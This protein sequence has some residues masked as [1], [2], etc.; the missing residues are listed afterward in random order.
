MIPLRPA[1]SAVVVVAALSGCSVRGSVGSPPAVS[2]DTLEST[3]ADRL[4]AQVGQRPDSVSCPDRLEGTAGD[5]VRCTLTSGD[6]TYGITVTAKSVKDDRVGFGI[7]V[8]EAPQA[9]R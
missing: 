8:D 3:I 2:T 1:L 4:E 5:S 9:S 6:S 7:A